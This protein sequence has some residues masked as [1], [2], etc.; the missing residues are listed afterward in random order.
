MQESSIF[1]YEIGYGNFPLSCPGK[2]INMSELLN[3]SIPRKGSDKQQI[4]FF[5]LVLQLFCRSPMPVI[6]S[7]G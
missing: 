3:E 1:G 2:G 5:F 7:V 6:G 4:F